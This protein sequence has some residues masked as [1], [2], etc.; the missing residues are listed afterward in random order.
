MKISF[1]ILMAVL[2][3]QTLASC[4]QLQQFLNPPKKEL[5]P[6]DYLERSAKLDISSFLNGNLEGFAIIQDVN[7][8]IS[9]SYVLRVNGKWE[10]TR[11]TV[12]FNYTF[13]GGKKDSRTWLVT[14]N[15]SMSYSAIGHD[16]IETA[17]GR[18]QGNAS[19]VNYSLNTMFKEIKQRI[20]YEDQLYLVDEKSAIIISTMRKSGEVVGKAIISLK[21]SN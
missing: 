9:D 11:G 21:K 20:D 19:A 12:Q 10:E 8:K 16:F 6:V 5:A 14:V 18:T 7:G 3:L 13:N 1:K 17:Q 2:A 4:A 15:D